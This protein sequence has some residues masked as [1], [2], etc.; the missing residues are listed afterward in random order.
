MN[1]RLRE[2]ELRQRL[3]VLRSTLLRAEITGEGRR[4]QTSLRQVERGVTAAR[5]L[6]SSPVVLGVAGL[7]TVLVGPLRALHWVGR[8]L[9][10][11]TLVRRVVKLLG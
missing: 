2:L 11:L 8:G 9:V 5:R 10:A 3:L 4:I 1:A 6:V 7:A